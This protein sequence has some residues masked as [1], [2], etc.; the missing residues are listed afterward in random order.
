[1]SAIAIDTTRLPLL[2]LHELRLPAI[3]RL[4]QEFAERADPEGWPAARCLAVLAKLEIAERGRRRIE[5][6]L[7]EAH[8]PS[9]K[10]LDNFDFAVVPMLSK[11]C[12]MALAAGDTWLEKGANLLFFGPHGAG[13]EPLRRSARQRPGRER[14]SRAVRSHHGDGA[15]AAG[16]PPGPATRIGDRQARQIRPVDPRRPLLRAQGSKPRPASYSS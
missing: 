2:L 12:I 7:A 11:A 6:H 5:R 3:G 14:L 15:A 9:R 10:T 1:M 13:Q 16:R 8:L 4:W